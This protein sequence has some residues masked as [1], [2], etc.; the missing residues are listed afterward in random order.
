MDQEMRVP[1]DDLETS[2][3]DI[4]QEV[5]YDGKPFTGIGYEKTAHYD[6]EYR[7]VQG[8]G[9]G[10]CCSTYPNGQMMEQFELREGRPVGE[11][12]AWYPSGQI[13]EYV[14]CE[15]ERLARQWNENGVLLSEEET[16]LVREWYS[17][18][19]LLSVYRKGAEC[20]YYVK[21]GDWIV[22]HRSRR[23]SLVW[24]RE[25]MDFNE[26]AV[27]ANL[28]A[29]LHEPELENHLFLWLNHRLELDREAGTRIVCG[30]IGHPKPSV[31]DRAIFIAGERRLEEARPYLERALTNDRIPP[32][33][34]DTFRGTSRVHTRSIREQARI[35]LDK[36][37]ERE[38][39]N[40]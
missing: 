27:M 36:L 29:W 39:E 19:E 38:E 15:P 30:L 13:R 11:S 10:T 23:D 26:Q 33:E 28:D 1:L 7:F 14:R 2:D 16:G 34:R 17:T 20:I 32:A 22:K 35:A 40:R 8:R 5:T 3:Y 18:G 4:F 37:A 6:S 25:D 21:D 9:H 31:K 12:F 24:E